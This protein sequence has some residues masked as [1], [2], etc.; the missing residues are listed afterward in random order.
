MASSNAAAR[1]SLNRAVFV[2]CGFIF[3]VHL[4]QKLYIQKKKFE[5]LLLE[6]ISTKYNLNV[7]LNSYLIANDCVPQ[8]DSEVLSGLLSLLVRSIKA[9]RY[10]LPL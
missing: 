6:N 9:W 2:L 8:D 7:E 10:C 3:Y 5:L 1:H 4:V